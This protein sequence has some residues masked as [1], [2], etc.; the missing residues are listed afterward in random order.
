MH[1]LSLLDK[2]GVAFISPGTE[3]YFRWAINMALSKMSEK[4]L[5]I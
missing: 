2:R 4:L 5:H 1:T 3:G